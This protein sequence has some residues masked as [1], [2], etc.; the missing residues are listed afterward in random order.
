MKKIIRKIICWATGHLKVE[1]I[2]GTG[3][4]C[5]VCKKWFKNIK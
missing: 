3:Y 2:D 1:V 4:V 5:L